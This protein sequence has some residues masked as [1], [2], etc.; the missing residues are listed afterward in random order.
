[1]PI[2]LHDTHVVRH[3]ATGWWLDEAGTVEAFAPLDGRIDADVVVI[4]GGYTG[5]WTAWHLLDAGASVALLEGGVC[6]HGPSGR[7]GGFCESMWL[8]APALRERFGDGPARALLDSSS[9]SVSFIGDWCRS[10]G[11]DAWFDQ[12]GYM[13]VSTAPAFDDVGR[14]AVAAAAALGAP[15]RVVELSGAE[16]RARCDSAL[17]RRGVLIP[18]FATLQPARLALGLRRRLVERGARVFERS[19]VRALRGTEAET[20]SGRV[21][22]GAAV[23]AVG[24]AVRALRE[25]RGRLTVTSSHVVLTEPVP[26]V[27]ERIG[28]TGGE[29]ITDG[30]TLLHYFRTTRDGRI[31][32]GW[33]GGRLAYGARLNGRVEVDPEIASQTH[34]ALLRLF[35]DLAGRRI[36]HAWGGPIDVSPSHIPQIG[37]LP[38][39]P[40]H[41]A[42]GFTGNGVGPSQL[43]GRTLAS[44]ALDRRDDHTRLP[45][46]DAGPGARVPPEPLTW[47]GGS[48]V[49]SALIRRERVAEDG[50][51]ADPLTRA[52]CAAPRAMGMHLGR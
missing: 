39:A 17:F 21:R 7:N 44:L 12:S 5:M 43:A 19:H 6:G 26:D 31:L 14:E 3:N 40:V 11:V 2:T 30:R 18:D 50:G 23:L 15:E 1:M 28:W 33:G 37:T 10:E 41:F 27:I 38:D 16:V 29:C 9:D 24:S 52:I 45:I 36:D 35:P 46:V 22:A 34:A 42:F 51:E 47:L 49:R 48:L 20:A 4:G 25:L 13:C 8:S 32:L